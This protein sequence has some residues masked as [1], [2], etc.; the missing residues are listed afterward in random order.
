MEPSKEQILKGET[1][2][3]LKKVNKSNDKEVKD[4]AEKFVVEYLKCKSSFDYFCEKYVLIEMPGGD[5]PL[6]PYKPQSKLV[7]KIINDHFVLVLKSRQI[8]ISTII[9]AYSTWL[10]TF[11]DNAVIGII[12]K[13]GKEATDFARAIRTMVEKLPKW[14]GAKFDKKTEQSFILVN[15]AK[16][17]AAPVNPNAPEK[18]LRG[19]AI[20]FL[21]IDEAAFIKFLDEAWTSMI[22]ALSTN[23]MHAKK[24]NVPYGTVV[25]STPNKTVGP[26]KWFYEKYLRA[27]SGD[28]IFKE[29]IIHW[30]DVEELAEDDG[31]YETQCKLFDNDPKKIQQE[32]E[33]KFLATA[34]SFLGEETVQILQD[35]MAEPIEKVRLFNGEAWRYNQPIPGR[36]YISGVDTAPEHG[37]DKSAITVWDYAG[38]EQVFEY[39]GK[40]K[41]TDFCKVVE[42]VANQYPGLIVIESNSYGN[43]V[44]EHM[45]NSEHRAMVYYETRGNK[46]IPGLQ[47]TGKTR[48][49]MIDALYSLITE[50]PE[51]VKSKKLILEL[52]GLISKT[53]GRVEADVG[54]HDDLALA[55]ALAFFVHKYDPV[56]NLE[57]NSIQ[58]GMFRDVMG[59]NELQPNDFTNHS[60]IKEV[61]NNIWE[62]KGYVDVMSAF[63]GTDGK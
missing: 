5:V 56:M 31:W 44:V 32:L 9:Q 39:Q 8:G 37:E 12:S 16:V 41:V 4:V 10:C 21:V 48:P 33:L 38:L 22:P 6:K 63:F 18:T 60:I 54:C 23:Q 20:T 42:V 43:Q 57:T 14:M 29:F 62:N 1:M 15:G 28:D 11:F 36:F 45:C 50:F 30:K 47:T 26:G 51:S 13:D 59:L 61:K 19:K 58:G 2:G 7:N 53:N 25:L 34:G 17:F 52:I 27:V 40:L 46:K 35:I 49:L 3:N 55:T 24:Q